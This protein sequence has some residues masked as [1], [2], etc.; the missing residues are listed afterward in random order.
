MPPNLLIKSGLKRGELGDSKKNV[1]RTDFI[2][3][4]VFSYLLRNRHDFDAVS[5]MNKNED[6]IWQYLKETLNAFK[7]SYANQLKILCSEIG[8]LNESTI[9]SVLLG[10]SNELFS[11]GITWSRIIAFFVFV[12]ELTLMCISKKLPDS[13]LDQV[14]ESFSTLVKEKLEPW[15]NDHGGW[16]RISFSCHVSVMWPS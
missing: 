13:T 5:A 12:G 10:V 7:D 14:Y 2:L 4:N 15:I 1:I 6:D 9:G 3:E 11:E 8:V 16:V